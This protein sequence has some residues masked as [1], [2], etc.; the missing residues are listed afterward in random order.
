MRRDRKRGKERGKVT[1]WEVRGSEKVTQ[2]K[3]KKKGK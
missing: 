3:E 1:E 2:T